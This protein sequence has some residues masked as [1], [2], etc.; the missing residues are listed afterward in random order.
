MKIIDKYLLKGFVP[1]FLVA[2]GIA[3]SVLTI[4]F[5]WLYID[6]LM[7]KGLG[8]LELIELVS[9]RATGLVSMALP[10]G[11]LLS[12]VMQV[13]N[14]GERYELSSFKSAGISLMRLLRP[15]FFAAV[16]VAS[17]S[18]AFSEIVVPWGNLKFFS[19]LYDIRKARPN[20]SFQ[21]G[22]FNDEF[23]EY[24]MRIG[25]KYGETGLGDILIYG[26][27]SNQRLVNQMT[28][29]TGD[30]LTTA[31]KQFLVM[32]LRDGVQYQES[33]QGEG[34]SQNY[35]FV[36]IKFKN[37]QKVFDLSEFDRQRTNEDLF[38]N[39]QMMQ[40]SSQI[41]KMVDSLSREG[42]TRKN[43]L[44]REIAHQFTPLK[45]RLVQDT[46][47]LQAGAPQNVVS[48]IGVATS[49]AT[50]T[51]VTTTIADT[52]L[53]NIPPN[54]YDYL[55]KIQTYHLQKYYNAAEGKARTVYN[56]VENTVRQMDMLAKQQAKYVYELH[57]KYS[58]AAICIVFLFVGAPMGAIVRK[59]GF[60]FPILIAV[61]FFMF[62]IVSVIYCKNLEK[63]NDLGPVSAAW[64]PVLIMVPLAMI[65]TYRAVNDYKIVNFD[66]AT[67]FKNMVSRFKK[68]K[69]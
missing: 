42:E 2:F 18:V 13:G 27:G 65:L 8:M 56:T 26:K 38:K 22:V 35:P 54:M 44:Q 15:L 47:Q 52:S 28:A 3:L 57:M 62:F 14:L 16:I 17:V 29:K 60:G 66:P 21:E 46:T 63:T 45:L 6:E 1:P 58:M 39:N 55:P 36:R 37:W 43:E 51:K 61:F 5:F 69:V 49:T 67:T 23:S 31:D 50:D 48:T 12:T 7:G 59:G 30:M 10:V 9:Y 64:L 32:K 53:N 24:T 11:I 20:I 34:Q 19:R 4:Q 68:N 41:L 25:K 40:S 33:G